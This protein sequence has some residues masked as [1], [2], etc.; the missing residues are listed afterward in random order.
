MLI[1]QKNMFN[2]RTFISLVPSQSTDLRVDGFAGN[3][4]DA[5]KNI[6]IDHSLHLMQIMVL[7][8]KNCGFLL[9][10]GL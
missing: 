4:D 3:L 6:K 2:I 7:I 1:T 8:L 10:A 5:L 9:G